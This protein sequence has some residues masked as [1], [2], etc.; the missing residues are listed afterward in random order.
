[1][2]IKSRLKQQN[3]AQ[4]QFAQD[5]LA[6][7]SRIPKKLSSKYFYDETGDKLFQDIMN[8][9]EY[10][11]TDAEYEIFET[12]KH[13]ILQLIGNKPFDLIEL[14]A[15]DGTKTKV[16]LRYF[17][18]K[19]ADFQYRP[20]DISENVLL[21]L[22]E[23]LKANVPDLR[24]KSLPGDYFK[25]LEKLNAAHGARKV[26][27]F[28]GANIGNLTREDATAFLQK[29]QQNMDAGDFLLIGFDLKK[30]PQVILNAYNDPSG[31]TAAFNL[32]LLQRMNRELSAD[33][34]VDSFKHW[35]TYNP[36]TGETKS[37]LVSTKKQA[38]HILDET[39][40]FDAWEAIDV[41]LSLKYSLS[42][43]ENLAKTTGFKV[44]QHFFDSNNYFVDT[45]WQK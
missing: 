10:Y 37:Y 3:Q 9:P 1:M 43:I 35:E 5:V 34:Q 7:L 11:L 23:D 12:H 38:V 2:T 27:L 29:I 19:G 33:F 44:T 17:L 8:M 21:E 4:T 30:D 28:I 25:M 36:A 40:S 31:I 15:G 32:N 20:I 42:E 39:F 26:I 41:E 24:V 22:E 14:G 45:L 18:A 6:G 16:L 13:K